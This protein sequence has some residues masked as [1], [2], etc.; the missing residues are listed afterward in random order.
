MSN[1]FD[2]LAELQAEAN[3]FEDSIKEV[4]TVSGAKAYSPEDA[5]A[6]R[7]YR[8]SAVGANKAHQERVTKGIKYNN[9]GDI[10]AVGLNQV[11]QVDPNVLF[12]IPYAI[13]E[14]G[15]GEKAKEVYIVVNDLAFARSVYFGQILEHAPIPVTKLEKTKNGFEV[16]STM[17]MTASKVLN[18]LMFSDIEMGKKFT[19]AINTPPKK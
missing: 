15:T 12:T 5:A 8:E 2:K 4:I 9:D 10:V 13:V 14:E 17:R 7:A 19:E 1:Q 6:I 11:H 18:G 3:K 16:I